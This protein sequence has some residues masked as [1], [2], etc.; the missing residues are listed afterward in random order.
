[1]SLSQKV[2][3][4]TL[5]QVAT[6][7]V[8]VIFG[9]LTTVLLTGYLGR[10]GFG[11]YMYVLTL[12]VVFGALADWGTA[13]IGVREAAKAKEKQGQLL[14]NLFL[15]RLI[16]ALLAAGA[17]IV[18]AWL[19]PFQTTNLVPVRQA[20]IL[21][22]GVLILLATKASLRVI[23]QTQLKMENL[24][25][26]DI[27]A[28]G[29]TLL[30]SWF[31]VNQRLGLLPLVG[32][33]IGANLVAV[34]VAW[35]LAQKIVRFDFRWNRN[36]IRRLVAESLPMGAIL[37]M[38]TMD[39]KIDTIMLGTIK[40]SGAVGIY[41]VAYRIY[42]VLILGA[43]Y[44][45]NVLLPVFSQYASVKKKLRRIYQQAFDLLFLMGLV[46]GLLNWFLAPLMV[47]L[48]TQNRLL[49]F[50]DAIGVLRRLS[51]ALLLAYLNHLTG[52]TIV[53][54]GRQRPYFFVALVS[55]VFNFLTN[56]WIIPRFSYF[57]AAT[58]TVLTEALVLVI[59]TF[60]VFRLLKFWPSL[61]R[62]PQTAC[63][64]FK[65]KGKIF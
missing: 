45:M 10:E 54:L 14:A 37:L 21:G 18:A 13:T 26:A 38:F 25:V 29:L 16:L 36:L 57:G 11:D 4:N 65:K 48:I 63:Q 19:L 8:T 17:M 15:L 53:A 62:F 64:L 24:A 39:N 44:L 43:A 56:L 7:V 42:D 30:F 6:K 47:R 35:F 3:F 31:L 9:L 23:F 22:S 46:V 20:I 32:A 27:S 58:V 51:L 59:T 52:Y 2:V 60:F 5:I 33:L 61:S 49:E 50:G 41:A 55:L 40:G 1:M 34:L 28:S 12:V